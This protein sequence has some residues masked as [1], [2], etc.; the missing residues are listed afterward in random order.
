MLA[1]RKAIHSSSGALA[2]IGTPDQARV[3]GLPE[4]SPGKVRAK[5]AR[6]LRRLSPWRRLLLRPMLLSL[7]RARVDNGGFR[8]CH[9]ERSRPLSGARL[10]LLLRLLLRLLLLLLLRLLLLLLLRLLLLPQLLLQLLLRLLCLR[11]GRVRV[12]SGGVRPC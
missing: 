12:N 5:R 3:G 9:P 11:L 6:P 10:L 4:V 7:G 1:A 2:P 8:P